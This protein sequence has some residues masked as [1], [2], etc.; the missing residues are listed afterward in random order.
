MDA[1]SPPRSGDSASILAAERC[2]RA[3]VRSQ[4]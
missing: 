1:L 4:R 3:R 2:E